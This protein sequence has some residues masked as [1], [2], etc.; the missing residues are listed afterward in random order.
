MKEYCNIVNTSQSSTG[1][2]Q[3]SLSMKNYKDPSTDVF[4]SNSSHSAACYETIS[5]FDSS[6]CMSCFANVPGV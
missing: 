2:S 3:F 5:L 6:I 4:T 1:E